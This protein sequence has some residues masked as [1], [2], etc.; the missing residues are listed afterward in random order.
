MSRV[1]YGSWQ[2]SAWKVIAEVDL[3]AGEAI[4]MDNKLWH[5]RCG[6]VGKRLLIRFWVTARPAGTP[7]GVEAEAARGSAR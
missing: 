5:G 7:W 6:K 3:R 1:E 4:I 2:H